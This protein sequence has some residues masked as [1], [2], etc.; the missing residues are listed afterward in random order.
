M[1]PP[2]NTHRLPHDVAVLDQHQAIYFRSLSD[3]PIAQQKGGKEAGNACSV[4]AHVPD[5]NIY[6]P[7][8]KTTK[9][10]QRDYP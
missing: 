2:N 4:L 1:L 7:P 6:A 10:K 9:P 8:T 5:A 3:F